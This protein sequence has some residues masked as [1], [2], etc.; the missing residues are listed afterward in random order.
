MARSSTME[1]SL[2]VTSM[3]DVK[4]KINDVQ[5]FGDPGA[6][7][8]LG[9]ASSESQKWMKSTKAMQTPGG[10]L[11]QVSTQQQNPDGSYAVAE[12]IAFVPGGRLQ[13]VSGNH[14]EFAAKQ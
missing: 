1:K 8:L 11:V 6:W 10:V 14:W 5:V 2:S 4:A 13:Q 3:D 12:A 9:K 7:V